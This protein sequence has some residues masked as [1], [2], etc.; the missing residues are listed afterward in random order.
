MKFWAIHYYSVPEQLIFLIQ[1][2]DSFPFLL[3]GNIFFEYI[4]I[5]PTWFIF[6]IPHWNI[7][8]IFS[9]LPQKQRCLSLG[10]GA[11]DGISIIPFLIEN[12]FC[13]SSISR[14]HYS[15]IFL[16]EYT[17]SPLYLNALIL[18]LGIFWI[19]SKCSS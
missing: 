11:F 13:F 3:S 5:F 17:I 7:C 1:I 9:S 16:S 19:S 2:L 18:I 8:A 6:F 4:C 15:P 14:Q 12:N 10:F